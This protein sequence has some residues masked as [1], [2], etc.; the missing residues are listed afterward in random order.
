MFYDSHAHIDLLLEKLMEKP[1]LRSENE[2]EGVIEKVDPTKF[3]EVIN[4][5]NNHDL[6][7]QPG[8][9]N[10]NTKFTLE[11][12]KD[13]EKVKILLGAHPELVKTDFNLRAFLKEQSTLLEYI[14]TNSLLK[15]KIIGVG[16]CG[17]DYYYTQDK[18]LISTQKDLFHS[19]INLAIMLELP[20][21]IHCRDAFEDLFQI[22]KEYPKIHNKFEIH[23]FT[24][25]INELDEVLALGGLVGIGG[26]VTFNSAQKLQDAIALCPLESIILETD[27]PFLSP[28]PHRG[29]LCLPEYIDFIAQKIADL[30]NISIDEVWK[31]TRQNLDRFYHF[32]K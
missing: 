15:T 2:E 4:Y 10:K 29:G 5:L 16:E 27:L 11:L 26:I 19:Q 18:D 24:G 21:I 25:G 28:I 32:S 31:I 3:D 1:G 9:S 30:K 6:V 14:E 17:L 8:I 22:L 13:I 7:I 23:C 20:L 12:W